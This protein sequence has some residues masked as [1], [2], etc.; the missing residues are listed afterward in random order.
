MKKTI[1]SFMLL[2]LIIKANSQECVKFVEPK[3]DVQKMEIP[4]DYNDTDF[5]FAKVVNGS[6]PIVKKHYKT[7]K[8]KDAYTSIDIAKSRLMGNKCT[9]WNPTEYMLVLDWIETIKPAVAPIYVWQ[10]KQ[11]V[12]DAKQIFIQNN[13]KDGYLTIGNC[14]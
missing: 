10:K 13:T 6:S 1:I 11:G 12:C 3:W 2:G 7:I 4:T 14:N 9:K 5:E 8:V